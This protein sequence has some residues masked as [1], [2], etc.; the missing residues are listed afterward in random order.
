MNIL[1]V[2]VSSSLLLLL[3]MSPL[4]LCHLQSETPKM[5]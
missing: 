4:R 3:S 1:I 2:L 5:R